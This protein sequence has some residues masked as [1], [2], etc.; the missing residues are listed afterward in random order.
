MNYCDH[1]QRQIE[2]KVDSVKELTDSS[3][4]DYMYVLWLWHVPFQCGVSYI[5]QG[6]A[7]GEEI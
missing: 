6:A 7:L 1:H 3:G 2:A 5:N 4:P